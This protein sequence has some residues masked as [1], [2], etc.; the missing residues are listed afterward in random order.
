MELLDSVVCP[1]RDRRWLAKTWPVLLIALVPFVALLAIVLMKGWR[2]QMTG[3]LARG[4][5]SLPELDLLAFLRD[6]AILWA[7]TFAYLLVPAIVCTVLGIGGPLGF[8]FDLLQIGTEGVQAWS[9]SEP[10]DWLASIAYYSTTAHELG[11]LAARTTFPAGI[12]DTARAA[13]RP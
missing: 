8:V 12:A 13:A 2:L 4:E 11:R 3:R 9:S 10:R 7:F 6:G 5:T 1:V